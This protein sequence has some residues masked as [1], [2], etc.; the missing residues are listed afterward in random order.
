MT[1]IPGVLS[2]PFKGPRKLGSMG[3][4]SPHLAPALPQ[5]QLRIVD[6]SFTDLPNGRQGQ[7]LVSTPTLLHGYHGDPQRSQAAFHAGWFITGALVW[8]DADALSCLLPRPTA[9]LRCRPHTTPPP[10][11][12]ATPP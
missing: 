8:P 4:V 3:K 5:P 7:L 12:T 11:P 10:P 6:E 9:T 1:E 2:N